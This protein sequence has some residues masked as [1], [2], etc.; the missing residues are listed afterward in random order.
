MAGMGRKQALAGRVTEW[1]HSV[2]R[3][4]SFKL[5]SLRIERVRRA[6][7]ELMSATGHMSAIEDDVTASEKGSQ[8][9][10]RRLL[11][12]PLQTPTGCL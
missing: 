12:G 6:M 7:F 9:S 3:L 1:W 11:L 4:T 2:C 8:W 10:M 5:I